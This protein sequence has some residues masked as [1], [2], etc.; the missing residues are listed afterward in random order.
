MANLLRFEFRKVF[1]SKYLYILLAAAIGYVLLTGGTT[2]LLYFFA[3]E[4]SDEVVDE[5]VPNY[6]SYSFLKGILTST[7]FMITSVFVSILACEDNGHGTS[8][9]IF[10][11]GYNRLQVY[12]SKYIAS[13]VMD[14][15]IALICVGV[16][17]LFALAV[18]GANTFD[19]GEDN[20]AVIILGLFLCVIVYHALHFAVASS[21]GKMA[22]AIV[23]NLL[24]PTGLSLVLN[25]LD[26]AA[27][28]IDLTKDWNI[29]VSSY[30]IDGIT[31]NF[32]GKTNPDLYV[33]DF[34]LIF[35]YLIAAELVGVLIAKKKQY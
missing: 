23:F 8:K 15:A 13:L 9:N 28:N 34:I 35:V 12:F 29:T 14:I 3:K 7:F 11:K 4:L 16:G 25:I 2:Y 18:F 22:G 20:V 17:A 19:P 27:A 33:A 26:I 10:A 6:T 32:A 21:I 30:W 24:V 5:I 31:A 1:R